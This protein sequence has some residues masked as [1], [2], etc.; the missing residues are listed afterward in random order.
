LGEFHLLQ[1]EQVA[2]F[3]ASGEARGD[4]VL[5]GVDGSKVG[6]HF[7]VPRDDVFVIEVAVDVVDLIKKLPGEDVRESGPPGDDVTESLAKE[8]PGFVA[9][10]ELILVG[11]G[12]SVRRVVRMLR[13]VVVG[14]PVIRFL[15]A[16]AVVVEAQH[17]QHPTPLSLG[18]DRVQCP[19]RV[20]TVLEPILFAPFDLESVRPHPE[21]DA[22]DA[23]L[24]IGGELI[25][26][27]ISAAASMPTGAQAVE[28]DRGA[29]GVEGVRRNGHAIDVHLH[30]AEHLVL[31]DRYLQVQRVLRGSE[32]IGTEQHHDRGEGGW[33]HELSEAHDLRGL[34]WQSHRESNKYSRC[35]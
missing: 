12:T 10:E 17:D 5:V 23:G 31:A 2:S 34:R 33:V 3:A 28:E 7:T 6:A 25:V 14:V 30:T 20:Q 4:D 21:P 8:I 26:V 9:R 29:V 18:Q 1:R 11:A 35:A 24:L 19:R 15:L 13:S 27:V 32:G 16:H 22:V